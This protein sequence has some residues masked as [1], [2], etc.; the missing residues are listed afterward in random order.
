MTTEEKIN[1][2]LNQPDQPIQH[3]EITVKSTHTFAKKMK[4]MIEL[5]E[6]EVSQKNII[7]VSLK[8]SVDKVYNAIKFNKSINF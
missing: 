6:N 1:Y 8:G 3:Q 7:L 2:I 5:Q 4:Q